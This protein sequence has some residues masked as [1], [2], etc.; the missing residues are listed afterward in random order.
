MIPLMRKVMLLLITAAAFAQRPWPP[1]G[2]RCPEVT[3]VLFEAQPAN[4]AKAKDLFNEHLAFLTAQ[5]KAGKLVSG[6]PTADRRGVMLFSTTDWPPIEEL[7]KQEPF[8]RE[9]VMKIASHTVWTS[10]SAEK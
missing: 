1:A 10:C 3:L 8:L 5:M 6:G 9:G 4:A 2:L 7:L